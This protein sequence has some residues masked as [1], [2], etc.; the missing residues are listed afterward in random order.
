MNVTTDEVLTMMVKP[1]VGTWSPSPAPAN[2]WFWAKN[3][4]LPDG[5]ACLHDSRAGLSAIHGK[6][7]LWIGIKG[8]Q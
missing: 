3:N 7:F 1:T 5:S 4:G 2:G 6:D 8:Q